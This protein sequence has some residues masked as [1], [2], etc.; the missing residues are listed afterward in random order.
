MIVCKFGGSSLSCA[1]QFKKVKKIV[2][3]DDERKVIVVS[4]LGKRNDSDIKITDLLYK[5]HYKVCNGIDYSNEWEIFY[6]RFVEVRDELKLQ[7]EIEYDLDII[8]HELIPS[9]LES[10]L[11]SR[12]EYLTAKLMSAY[13][14]YQFV[15]AKDIIKFNNDGNLDETLTNNRIV[16]AYKETGIVVPGFYGSFMDGNIKLLSRGGSDVTGSILSKALQVNLYENWTDVSGI[17]MADPRIVKNPKVVS[18]LTYME[19]REL[20]YMG[21]N[22]LHEETIFPVQELNI[23]INLRNTNEPESEGTYIKESVTGNNVITG[24]A[25]KK[26]FIAY[27][28]YKRHLSNEIGFI[29]KVLEIFENRNI[30]IEHVPTG[31]DSISV[32]VSKNEVGINQNEIIKE[33]NLAV[34]PESIEVSE[35][36]A[37]IAVVG[38]NM[39]ERT[40]ISGIIFKTLGDNNINVKLIAQGLGEIDVILGVLNKDYEKTIISLYNN[41]K[42]LKIN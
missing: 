32:V 6:D 7:Y 20:S 19:L 31:I 34:N 4:A 27:N 41:L 23:P 36:M 39:K 28:I 16:V 21:A 38:R 14:G 15:D 2:S 42:D 18:E 1:K 25:G 33:I 8:K 22:V 40:G 10:Y 37:L 17:M 11:V 24:I 29:R 30:S 9:I 3:S 12:G 26:G 13:L 35:E 5:M